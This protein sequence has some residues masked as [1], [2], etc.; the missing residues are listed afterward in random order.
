M[1]SSSRKA[2]LIGIPT[3]LAFAFALAVTG[4][5]VDRRMWVLLLIVATT[6]LTCSSVA[7]YFFLRLFLGHTL[8][9]G[10]TLRGR[11][12]ALILAV[13]AFGISFGSGALLS[14]LLSRT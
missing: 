10:T 2:V 7:G 14:Y 13:F 1:S 3:M 4:S 8:K 9:F 6:V 11:G 12:V 5:T